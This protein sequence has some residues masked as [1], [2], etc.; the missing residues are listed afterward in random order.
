MEVE[1]E[2]ETE[3]GTGSRTVEDEVGE[4]TSVDSKTGMTGTGTGIGTGTGTG[5]ETGTQGM[6]VV[7]NQALQATTKGITLIRDHNMTATDLYSILSGVV[8][9]YSIQSYNCHC[10]TIMW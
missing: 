8:S 1:T 5:I 9:V 7:V 2:A 3:A 4:G 10:N 6:E